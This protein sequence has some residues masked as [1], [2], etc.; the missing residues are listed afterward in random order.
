MWDLFGLLVGGLVGN[1]FE[2]GPPSWSKKLQPIGLPTLVG[3]GVG[4]IIVPVIEQP[5]T[6]RLAGVSRSPT[7]TLPPLPPRQVL[8]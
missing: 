2:N 5:T 7:G 1:L 6:L 8:R 3:A 4:A